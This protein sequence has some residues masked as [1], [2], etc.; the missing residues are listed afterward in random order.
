MQIHASR[1]GF[2]EVSIPALQKAAFLTVSAC[3]FFPMHVQRERE[4]LPLFKKTLV[5][6]ESLVAQSVKSLP[7]M[8]EIQV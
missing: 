1:V 5:V 8:Q 7:A 6:S 4:S 3:D 2:W